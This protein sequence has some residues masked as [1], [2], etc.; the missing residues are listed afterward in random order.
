MELTTPQIFCHHSAFGR[1][2]YEADLL[3]Q[4]IPSWNTVVYHDLLL[5]TG[6]HLHRWHWHWRCLHFPQCGQDSDKP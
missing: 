3:L 4:F 1:N 2:F 5:E 6:C